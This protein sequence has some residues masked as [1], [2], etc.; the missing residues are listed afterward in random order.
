MQQTLNKKHHSQVTTAHHPSAEL[1][2]EIRMLG[3]HLHPT[4][5]HKLNRQEISTWRL[6]R[7][8]NKSARI[9]ITS[10]PTTCFSLSEAKKLMVAVILVNKFNEPIVPDNNKTEESTN[11]FVNLN[12]TKQRIKP[13]FV[14]K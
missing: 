7:K 3:R 12:S 4:E 1:I 10:V 5:T 11:P 9:I 6:I 2:A 13:Y 8:K 14:R